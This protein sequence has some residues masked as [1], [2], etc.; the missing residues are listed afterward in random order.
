LRPAL[1]SAMSSPSSS[2]IS[3][4]QS[5]NTGITTAISRSAAAVYATLLPTADI[6]NALVTSV[7]SYDINLFLNG[8]EQVVNG[9]PVNGL[10]Y[11]FGAPVAADVAL[12]TLAGGFE[13]VAFQK[14]AST[15]YYAL[16]GKTPPPPG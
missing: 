13:A 14:A 10:V 2:F 7:P 1:T 16:M 4:L 11:A 5:A 3:T 6:A 15:I 12:G 9:D 8:I